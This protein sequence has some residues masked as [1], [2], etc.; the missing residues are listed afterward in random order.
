MKRAFWLILFGVLVFAA[1]IV[2]RLPAGWIM[3]GPKSGITCSDVDGTIW[4]GTCTGLTVQQQAIGDVS[5]E[6]HAS[7]LLAGKL[8]TDLVLTRPDGTSHGNV[9]VGMDKN[10][11]ARDLE[12]DLP[13]EHSL[14]PL[15]PQD[16]HGKLHAEIGSLRVEKNVITA[17]QG[18]LE[19][20]D[21]LDGA[22]PAAQRWGSYSLT[23]PPAAEGDPVGQL[24]DLGG[25]PL[26]VKGTLKLTSNPAGFD[27]EGQVKPLPTTPPDLVQQIQFLGR[28][29]ADG[30]RPF[31][32]QNS[33]Y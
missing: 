5:W 27:L 1:I 16:L 10:L 6:V 32:M 3:P 30:F 25:G 8:N 28:P 13:L 29:D 4:S 31:G 19:A 33:F 21:L 9:E 23:F 18:H 14:I 24:R 12:A 7:R 22:G 11:T 17:I 15:L 2:A 20:R 26:Q